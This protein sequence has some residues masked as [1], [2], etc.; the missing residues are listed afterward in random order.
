M[1]ALVRIN[2]THCDRVKA[3]AIEAHTIALAAFA[4]EAQT[5]V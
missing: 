3:R 4:Y 5:L 1:V 2:K